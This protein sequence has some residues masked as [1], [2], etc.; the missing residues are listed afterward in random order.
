LPDSSLLDGDD[1]GDVLNDDVTG[2]KLAHDPGHLAPE[3]GFGVIE[4]VALAGCRGTFAWKTADDPIDRFSIAS[5]ELPN[6]LEYRYARPALGK[7]FSSP[8]VEFTKPFMRDPGLGE[9][10][11]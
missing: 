1:V 10:H 7:D 2:S 5:T 4:S 11:I 3:N 6:V 9:S 8:G